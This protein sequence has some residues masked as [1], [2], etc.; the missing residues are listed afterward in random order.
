[1]THEL[2]NDNKKIECFLGIDCGSVSIKIALIDKNKK[3]VDSV[4]LK[5]RGIIETI[6][7]GMSQLNNDKYKVCGVGVTGSGRQ[8][9]G[10]L[11]GADVVKTEILAHAIA[12]LNY[13]PDVRTIMDIGGED[14]KIMTVEN[15]V[16]TDFIMNNICGAGTG[17]VIETI[18]SRL[19]VLIEDVG[20]LA[21]QSTEELEFPGKCGV[22]CQSAVVSRLNSGAAKSDIL[23]GVVS[24]LIHNYLNLAKSINLSP[25]YVFQGATAQNKALVA[26]LSE[27]LGC[28]VIIPEKCSVMGAIGSALL[29]FEANIE[30]TKFKSFDM[31][32]LNFITKNFRC[33]DCPNRCEVTQ[34]FESDKLVGSIGSRCGK[35]DNMSR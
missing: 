29:A 33:V 10:L 13:Y 9:V 23:K 25:P 21:M 8:F 2:V 18:A 16:L 27:Q 3:L 17:A 30:E 14:C 32:Q 15:G 4:Y 6:K 11:V 19:G 5:N 34:L 7:Q 31:S 26:A 22:F 24:A 20:D 1:M 35:W 12:T 28:E